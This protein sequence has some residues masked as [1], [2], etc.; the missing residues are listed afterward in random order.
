VS[1][2]SQ[3]GA[4]LGSVRARDEDKG[5]N[6]EIEYRIRTPIKKFNIEASSGDT[7]FRLL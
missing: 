6:G 4:I 3:P 2:N 5:K 1:E 7:Y